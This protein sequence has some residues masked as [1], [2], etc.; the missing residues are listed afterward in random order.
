M[1]SFPGQDP[2][3]C[4]PFP[5]ADLFSCQV[6]DFEHPDA[7]TIATINREQRSDFAQR[8]AR[9]CDITKAHYAWQVNLNGSKKVD[10]SGEKL[11]SVGMNSNCFAGGNDPNDGT[12]VARARCSYVNVDHPLQAY[13]LDRE[14]LVA[15]SPD[16]KWEASLMTCS[17]MPE[18]EA[19]VL[20]DLQRVIAHNAAHHTGDHARYR[21]DDPTNTLVCELMIAPWHM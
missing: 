16:K 15:I 19:Q 9:G 7:A 12:H 11:A 5:I 14:K 17:L 20:E 3:K 13:D 8:Q 4:D 1:I 6:S 21:L 10:Y 18:D 2:E